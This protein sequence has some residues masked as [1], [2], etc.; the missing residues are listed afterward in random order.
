MLKRSWQNCLFCT[1]IANVFVED[2]ETRN[3]ELFR[4]GRKIYLAGH[5]DF[6]AC[7]FFTFN[8]KVN[9][10]IAICKEEKVICNDFKLTLTGAGKPTVY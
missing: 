9:L 1:S 2:L 8:K 6:F 3:L 7:V 5:K 10:D 4:I